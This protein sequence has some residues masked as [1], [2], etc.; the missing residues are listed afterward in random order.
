MLQEFYE[1]YQRTKDPVDYGYYNIELERRTDE[2]CFGDIESVAM[3]RCLLRCWFGSIEKTLVNTTTLDG[4][5]GHIDSIFSILENNPL[6][7]EFTANTKDAQ[8][9]AHLCMIKVVEMHYGATTQ[10]HEALGTVISSWMGAP[11][12]SEV[13]IS[14][15]AMVNYLYGPG[16]WELYGMDVTVEDHVPSYLF[17]QG[18]PIKKHEHRV[19]STLSCTLPVDL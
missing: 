6:V 1:K 9:L 5:F 2:Y 13:F 18:L 10:E 19:E 12:P 3:E 15:P 11:A 17:K 4:F 16:V 8:I 14:L 7:Q